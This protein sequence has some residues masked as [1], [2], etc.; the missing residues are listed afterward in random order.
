MQKDQTGTLKTLQSMSEFSELSKHQ[1]NPACRTKSVKVFIMVKQLGTIRKKKNLRRKQIV[2]SRKLTEHHSV[3]G[4]EYQHHSVAGTEFQS[5]IADGKHAGKTNSNS[6]KNKNI[7]NSNKNKTT[8]NPID[9]DA[10]SAPKQMEVIL[11]SDLFFQRKFNS[12]T[13]EKHS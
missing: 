6:N 12:L 2:G 8:M 4:T 13:A 1:N 10:R 3:A 11:V 9:S 7:S 5:R